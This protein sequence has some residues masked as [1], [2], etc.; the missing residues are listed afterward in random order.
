MRVDPTG[1]AA[2]KFVLLSSVVVP[3]AAGRQVGERG[4]AA[5]RIGKAH[6]RP[7]M[8]DAAERAEFG[9]DQHT[10]RDAVRIGVDELDPEQGRERERMRVDAVEKRHKP[11][12][13]GGSVNR[14]IASRGGGG[15]KGGFIVQNALII[16]TAVAIGLGLAL[17]PAQRTRAAG[18]GPVDGS[19]SVAVDCPDVGD[20]GATVG[21]SRLKCPRAQWP[22]ITSRQPTRAM[23]NLRRTQPAR[24]P[25]AAD[26]GRKD[27]AGS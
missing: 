10:R 21:V 27:G 11:S 9:L 20:G 2:T 13:A 8:S 25:S 4:G 7:A 18:A 14:G 15:Q 24:R 6:D 23:G 3:F 22:A 12:G 1:A 26:D 19:W 5:E 16:A 17:I